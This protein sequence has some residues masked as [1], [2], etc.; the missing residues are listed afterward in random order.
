MITEAQAHLSRIAPIPFTI[1]RI[2][3]HPEA[4]TL[5]VEPA[6]ALYPVLN[7][8]R[9][10]TSSAGI[11]GHTDTEPWRPHVSVAYSHATGPAAPIIEAV[12]RSLPETEI[13]IKS[14]SLVS[15]TQVGRSWQWKPVAEVLLTRES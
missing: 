4:V 2:G 12:G 13:T 10:A 11:D 5:L 8:V 14:V 9:D 15:Q 3:Y 6:N 1:S 7:A